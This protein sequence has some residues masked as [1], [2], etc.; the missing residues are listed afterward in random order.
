MVLLG[1]G[2]T[3]IDLDKRDVY[4]SYPWRGLV[5]LCTCGEHA[6][7]S[8]LGNKAFKDEGWVESDLVRMDLATG[9]TVTA[10]GVKGLPL[11]PAFEQVVSSDLEVALG[12]VVE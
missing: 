11:L 10:S 8:K 12:G 1:P 4:A 5:F 3:V 2:V 9:T 7:S 6:Y